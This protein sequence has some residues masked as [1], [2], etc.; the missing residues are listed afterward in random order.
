[1]WCRYFVPIPVRGT[2]FPLYAIL[3][4]VKVDANGITVC[5]SI[6]AHGITV[7]NPFFQNFLLK[8]PQTVGAVRKEILKAHTQRMYTIIKGTSNFCMRTSRYPARGG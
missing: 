5:K 2:Y 6:I 4:I 8:I 1:M 3:E 7:V